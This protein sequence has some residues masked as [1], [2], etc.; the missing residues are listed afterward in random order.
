[1]APIQTHHNTAP[2]WQL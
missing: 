1:M 2:S